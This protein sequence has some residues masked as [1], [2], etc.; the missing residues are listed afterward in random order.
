MALGPVAENALIHPKEKKNQR[1]EEGVWESTESEV[2]KSEERSKDIREQG[3][4]S[5][6]QR[7]LW[8]LVFKEGHNHL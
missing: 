8:K 1:E 3:K 6:K 2:R 5:R 7:R 4:S